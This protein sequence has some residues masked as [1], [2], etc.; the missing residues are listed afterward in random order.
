MRLAAP[1]H[2]P[3]DEG[4]KHPHLKIGTIAV[5]EMVAIPGM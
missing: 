2:R 3:R 5:H 1:A 4:D